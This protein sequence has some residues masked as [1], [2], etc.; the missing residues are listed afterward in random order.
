MDSEMMDPP[1]TPDGSKG[2]QQCEGGELGSDED[3]RWNAS[4]LIEI[5]ERSP[6]RDMDISSLQQELNKCAKHYRE[7]RTEISMTPRDDKWITF[8]VISWH[9]S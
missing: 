1:P 8:I 7:K 9:F 6:H 3:G 2:R 4:T 5:S